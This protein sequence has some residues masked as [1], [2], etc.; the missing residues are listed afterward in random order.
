VK[1][2][3]DDIVINYLPSRKKAGR[4][5][6]R[7]DAHRRQG[8]AEYFATKKEAVVRRNELLGVGV[9]SGQSKHTFA[10]AAE[11]RVS[12]YKDRY[13]RGDVKF[14]TSK[15]AKE[16]AAFWNRFFGGYQLNDITPDL[17]RNSINELLEFNPNTSKPAAPKT[18]K[19]RYTFLSSVFKYAVGDRLC[20]NNPC[21]AINLVELIGSTKATKHL[22]KRFSKRIVAEIITYGG[23]YVM[24]I[25]FA[26]KTGLRSGEQRGI[27]WHHIDFDAGFVTVE[28]AIV[29]GPNGLEI[30]EPKSPAAFR[31]VPLSDEMLQDLREWRLQ[32]KFSADTDFVFPAEDGGPMWSMQLNGELQKRAD[33]GVKYKGALK[34][35]CHRAGVEMIR[36]HDLRHHYASLQ[37]YRD[38][39]Q[40]NEVAALMG[41]ETSKITEEIYGHWLDGANKDQD[42]RRRAA[43]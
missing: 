42:L 23:R 34:S 4:K 14:T 11:H 17:I 25:K 7:L 2:S 19:N 37:L 39:V 8:K 43:V 9:A 3:T 35:A 26:V 40:L 28:Q 1:N 21:D 20:G 5:P 33:G 27:Q 30:G 15:D 24:H 38:G 22:A 13:E 41:H 12:V 32:S 29:L 10:G 6:W 16:S 18:I 31:N 36:W